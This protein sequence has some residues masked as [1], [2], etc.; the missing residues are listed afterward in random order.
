MGGG[1]VYKVPDG[2]PGAGNLLMVYHAEIPTIQIQSL[3]PYSPWRHRSDQGMSWTDLGEIIR[4]NQGYGSDRDGFDIGD[5]PL[6]VSPD[7]K[8]FN[9]YFY[10]RDW[11]ANGTTQGGIPPASRSFPWPARPSPP[12][13]KRHLAAS[14]TPSHFRSSKMA[15]VSIRHWAAIP[16]T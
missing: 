1:P 11:L 15:G 9:I 5:A 16:R 14:R 6:V 2:I 7:G 3:D 4:V 13:S 10:F 12:C 8:Y